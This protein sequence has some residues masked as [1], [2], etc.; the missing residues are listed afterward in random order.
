MKLDEDADIIPQP[1]F[2]EKVFLELFKITNEHYRNDINQVWQ[3]SQYF[4]LADLGLLAFFYSQAFDRTHRMSVV[5]VSS[6]GLVLSLFWMLITVV[7]SRWI[8]VW[9]AKI[10]KLER[11]LVYNGPFQTGE[12]LQGTRIHETFRPQHFATLLAIC[13]STLWAMILADYVHLLH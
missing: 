3:R 6:I 8:A 4:M 1:P 11:Y 12:A 13:F 9:R 7:T 5:V 10:I 2:D